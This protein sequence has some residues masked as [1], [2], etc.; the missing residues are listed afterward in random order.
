MG[1]LQ[2]TAIPYASAVSLSSI[3]TTSPAPVILTGREVDP[4]WHRNGEFNRAAM[5]N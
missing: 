5:R 3:R 2:A 4:P 1:S